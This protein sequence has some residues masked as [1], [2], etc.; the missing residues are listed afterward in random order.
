MFFTDP[1]GRK[2]S[3]TLPAGETVQGSAEIQAV[4]QRC[5]PGHQV[6]KRPFLSQAAQSSLL[7]QKGSDGTLEVPSLGNRVLVQEMGSSESP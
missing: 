4:T 2:S 7:F 1:W 6:Q 5:W 3:Q